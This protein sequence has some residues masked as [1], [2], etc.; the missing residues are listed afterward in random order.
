M[1]DM[2]L[3][4]FSLLKAVTLVFML[5]GLLGLI[6]PIFPGIIIIWL[7][8][9]IYAVIA[10]LGGAMTGLDWFLFVLVTILAAFG[11][12]VDNFILAAKLRQTGTPWKSIII[13]Y[14]AGLGVSFFFTPLVGLIVTPA[15]LYLVEYQ[16]LQDRSLAFAATKA[17]LIGFGWTFVAL[18]AIGS[19]MIGLWML[20][21]LIPL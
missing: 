10:G 16:R 4:G 11:T 5:I 12:V 2:T 14:L 3:L 18:F 21:A 6:V 8:A 7:S 20:W 13:A 15:A 1:V 17:F 19:A 9:L